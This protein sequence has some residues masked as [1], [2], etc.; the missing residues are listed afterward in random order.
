MILVMVVQRPDSRMTARSTASVSGD[1]SEIDARRCRR[2]FVSVAE[3]D[4]AQA[5]NRFASLGKLHMTVG[6]STP[7][8][9]EAVGGCGEL[10]EGAMAGYEACARNSSRVDHSRLKFCKFCEGGLYAVFHSANL[11]CDL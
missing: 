9:D 6:Y 11:R 3:C 7:R 4:R 10:L 2:A 8:S 5:G 1:D